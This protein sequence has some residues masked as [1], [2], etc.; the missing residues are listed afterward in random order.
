MGEIFEALREAIKASKN[1]RYRI[2]KELGIDQSVL[3]RFMSGEIGL[4]VVNVERI[5]DYLGL[6]I[7]FRVKVKKGNKDG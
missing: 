4:T 6:K 3:S 1:S 2:S 5:A 7:T